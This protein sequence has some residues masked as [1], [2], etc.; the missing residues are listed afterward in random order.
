MD[1]T[2]GLLI[3]TRAQLWI[4]CEPRPFDGQWTLT[5]RGERRDL[6]NANDGWFRVSG[7]VWANGL[8]AAPQ[9]QL[10]VHGQRKTTWTSLAESVPQGSTS[11]LLAKEPQGWRPGDAIVLASTS[12]DDRE[13]EEHVIQA[14][15][16]ARLTLREATRHAHDGDWTGLGSRLNAEVGILSR[17]VKFTSSFDMQSCENAFRNYDEETKNSCFGGHAVF[18]RH[19]VVH[20]EGAEF[21]KMGQALAMG[22]YA[23]HFHH[24]MDVPGSYLRSNSI[25][26]GTNRCV[27]LHGSFRVLL[28]DNVC[29]QNRGHNLYL[30][31]GIEWGNMF[32]RNL[33]VAPKDSAT[34]CTDNPRNLLLGGA[35]GMWITNPNNSFVDNTVVGA[36]FGAWFTFPARHTHVFS[37]EHRGE[38]GDVFGTSKRHFSDPASGYG[39]DSW[40]MNQE[41]A[42]TPVVAFNRNSFKGSQQTAITID[43]RVYN[44]EDAQIPCSTNEDAYKCDNC[45][46][47][48]CADTG[49]TFVW[50]PATFDT[51]VPPNQRQYQPKKQIFEDIVVAHTGDGRGETFTYWATGGLVSFERALFYNNLQGSSLGFTGEC[52]SGEAGLGNAGANVQFR[53]T[54]FMKG[55]APF[56]YYDG[57]YNCQH[58]RWTDLES[59]VVMRPGSPGNVNGLLMTDSA[60]LGWLAEDETNPLYSWIWDSPQ[61]SNLLPRGNSVPNLIDWSSRMIQNTWQSNAVNLVS[62]DGLAGTIRNG[63][64][65]QWVPNGQGAEDAAW[66]KGAIV[67]SNPEFKQFYPCLDFL[68]CGDGRQCSQYTRGR[69]WPNAP[70]N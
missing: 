2:G 10:E 60:P 6:S 56:K 8:I 48:T 4:G 37:G 3:D 36:S 1:L 24:A 41:Q 11:L 69:D 45:Q 30:E 44:S 38:S 25:R 7:A 54:L 58:C 64:F 51:N 15:N 65:T 68:W 46:C 18:L 16:G 52:A 70:W 43:F 19:S 67:A 17:N 26:R 34:I 5:F 39:P 50:A 66:G 9:A 40:V 32:K 55:A 62:T 35:S 59:L 13:S 53:N 27:T 57:G 22:R 14:V 21:D 61:R 42:R 23:L 28:E 31:D 29:F 20:V 49:H 47:P 12:P 33:V 63:A